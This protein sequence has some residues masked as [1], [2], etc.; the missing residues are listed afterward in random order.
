MNFAKL[1]IPLACIGIAG[2]LLINGKEGWGGFL[3][4]RMFTNN[5]SDDEE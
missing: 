2:Y 4:C 3:S 1:L 5:N